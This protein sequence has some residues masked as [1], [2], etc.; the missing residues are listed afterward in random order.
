MI[1]SYFF[2]IFDNGGLPFTYLLPGYN[3][4]KYFLS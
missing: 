3:K 1:H 2:H 4:F